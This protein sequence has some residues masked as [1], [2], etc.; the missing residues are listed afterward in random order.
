MNRC[1]CA[2]VDILTDEDFPPSPHE[3]AWADTSL[4]HW[5]IHYDLLAKGYEICGYWTA[6]KGSFAHI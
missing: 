2:K 3:A 6:S 4:A 5:M 1:Y